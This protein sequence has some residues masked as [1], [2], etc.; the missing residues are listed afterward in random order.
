MQHLDDL[1]LRRTRLGIL[2]PRGGLDHLAR[3]RELCELHLQWG[4]DG[5]RTEIA[6]YQG[7]IA[8]HYQWPSAKPKEP[9][10]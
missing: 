10:P 1:L 9:R 7:L 6:R 4:D 3:I 2:L 5:W 8:A